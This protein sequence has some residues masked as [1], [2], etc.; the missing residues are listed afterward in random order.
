MLRQKCPDLIISDTVWRKPWIL[1]V[2][3]W[4]QECG[5]LGRSGK[6]TTIHS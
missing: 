6:F 3:A 4:G 2:I 1:H 5:E